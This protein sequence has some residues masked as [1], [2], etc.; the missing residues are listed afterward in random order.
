MNRRGFIKK[1]AFG[2]AIGL[3]NTMDFSSG[4]TDDDV[5]HLTVL[6]TNDVHSR[7]DPFPMDGSR[8]EGEG[9]VIRRKQIIDRIRKE[10]QQTL[11]LD[12]GD[13]FQGTPYFNLFNG[14]LEIKLMSRLGYDGATMGNHDFD[15]GMDGFEKQLIHADFPIINSNYDFRDTI[16]ND[17]IESYKIWDFGAIRVGLYGLGIELE[18]LVAQNHYLNT[19]YLDPIVMARR[20]ER[21]LKNELDCDY[22]ICLSH[23]GYRYRDNKV[24]D[25]VLAESSDYTD[26]IIGGH[27]HTF[28][29]EPHVSKNRNGQ[30]V[31]INQA[32]WAG[33]LLGRIDLYFEKGSRR[34]A[35]KGGNIIVKNV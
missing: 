17:R 5:F 31:I 3:M 9:G 24:S 22:I 16:L 7:I 18:G 27:T 20:Y 6:H 26:L 14:E 11:L 28:M 25:V 2:A 34:K 4:W 33:I 12:A 8:N 15:A 10:G 13:I 32:G 35:Q 21:L 19:Q 23:L 29:K 30:P 1:S